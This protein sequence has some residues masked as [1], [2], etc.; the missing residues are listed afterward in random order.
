MTAR[1][2]PFDLDAPQWMRCAGLFGP[3]LQI[4]PL[5]SSAIHLSAT[6][7]IRSLDHVQVNHHALSSAAF[8]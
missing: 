1:S 7:E 4:Q 3:V 6:R 8:K 2:N 5:S